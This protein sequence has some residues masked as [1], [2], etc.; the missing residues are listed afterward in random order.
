MTSTVNEPARRA[1]AAGTGQA[2]AHLRK[3]SGFESSPCCPEPVLVKSPFKF[4][5]SK[6]QFSRTLRHCPVQL[7]RHRTMA[8]V[9]DYVGVLPVPVHR[10]PAIEEAAAR[11]KR[12]AAG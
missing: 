3:R 7:R 8:R 1:A 12:E 4:N 11:I 5:G 2:A 6:R 10:P 9:A